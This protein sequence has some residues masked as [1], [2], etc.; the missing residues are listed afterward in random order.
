MENQGNQVTPRKSLGFRAQETEANHWKE[1]QG[2]PT[3]TKEKQKKMKQATRL[4]K[5]TKKNQGK[6]RKPSNTK[7]KFRV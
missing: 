6:P 2:K 1:N 4:Q 3:K 5:K 7:E